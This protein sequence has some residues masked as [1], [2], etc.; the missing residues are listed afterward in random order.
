EMKAEYQRRHPRGNE[1]VLVVEVADTTRVFDL[2][3]KADLYASSGVPEYWVVDLKR[4]R[5]VIHREPDG[6][7]YR[8]IQVLAEDEMASIQGR[9]EQIRIS[10]LFPD[11]A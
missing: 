4:R 1:F 10:E 7:Q 9:P 2:S 11:R 8:Q 6:E 5:L 3:R